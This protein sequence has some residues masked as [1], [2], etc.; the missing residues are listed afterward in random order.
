[1]KFSNTYVELGDTFYQT[2]QPEKVAQ[3]SLLLW[4][5]QLAEELNL[6]AALC[7]DPTLQTEYFS[8][9]QL[10]VGANPVALAY[11]GHQFGHFN[12]QLGDGRA[13]LLGEIIDSNNI[14]R[15]IQLKGSGATY[16]SRGG[17][18]RCGIKPAVREYIMSEAIHALGVPTSRCLAVVTS[19]ESIFRDHQ[20][21][22]GAIVTRVASSH[23]RVGTFQYFATRDD[24][25]S[26]KALTDY[27]IKRHFPEITTGQ[28]GYIADFLEAVIDKQITMVVEWMRVGF[29]HG[30]M[31][32]DNTPI[33]GE[34]LDFGPCAMMGVYHP[35]TV[36]SSIDRNGRYAYGKQPSIAQWNMVR[37]A[38]CL[39]PLVDE[40]TDKA[41]AQLQPLLQQF[42]ERF[43]KAYTHMLNNKLG[44]TTDT[45]ANNELLS[46][47]LAK[48]QELELDYTQ[49][50][51]L[52]ANSLTDQTIEQQ[53]R[54]LLTDWYANWRQQLSQAHLSDIDTQQHMRKYNPLVI[55]RNHHVETVLSE[56]ERAGNNTA[57]EHFLKVLRS[58]YATT[59]DTAQF[60]TLPSDNDAN[61][62]TFCG[63]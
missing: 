18:G 28:E 43:E 5:D 59:A 15:D 2:A 34:T 53:V 63:T 27:S 3:P 44:L 40:D 57:V 17:D 54:A 32:T 61:Y 36:F 47:L 45:A 42:T 46:Q 39:L 35:H 20:A 9:N 62:K 24:I 37:L 31:N 13:H 22:P 14:R 33:C 12:P 58:P 26:L 1:M 29:I 38:E 41:I 49:T 52:L 51:D 7:Q 48:M 8:G 6:S 55:P 56:C 30:V 60:Q 25:P 50:F 16:F 23:I 4:N 11:A 19:G 21:V 10:P